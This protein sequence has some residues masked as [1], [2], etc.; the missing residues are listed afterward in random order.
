MASSFKYISDGNGRDFYITYN[1]GGL[2]AA[3]IPGAK[4]SDAEFISSLRNIPK[5]ND[6]ISYPSPKELERRKHSLRSQQVLIK[7]LTAN[8]K[9]WKSKLVI[10]FIF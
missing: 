2:Q 9:Q 6:P 10:C 3:Y 1:S 4:K 5:R 7:R 8:T